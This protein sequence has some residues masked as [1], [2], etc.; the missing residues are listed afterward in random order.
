MSA[1]IESTIG[2]AKDKIGGVALLVSAWIEIK[3]TLLQLLPLSVA[4]LVSAW[5]EIVGPAT[6]H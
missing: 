2:G 4:L 5:I 3:T 1:W 6:T